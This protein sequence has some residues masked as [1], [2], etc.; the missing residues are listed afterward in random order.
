M[1]FSVLVIALIAAIVLPV[2]LHLRTRGNNKPRPANLPPGS[3][4]LPVIGQSLA[5]LRAMRT[6]TA[7]RWIQGRVARYGPVSKLSLFG[8][9]TVL[10]T[11]PAAN[12]FVFFSD[13][14]LAMKQPRSVAMILGER[15]ISE[16]TGDDHRRIR[17]A[18]AEFLKPD[19]LRKY[20]GKI[21][22]EVRRHLDESWD[23]RRAVTVMPLMKRLTFGIISS[24]LFGLAPGH[25]R[26][27]LAGDFARIAEGM[28]AI[29]VDLPFTAFRRS[30]RSSARARRLL[31]KI[32]RETKAKLERGEASRSS[33]LIACL[34]SLADERGA[35]LLSEEEI[36]DN[37]MVTLVAGNDTSSV[38]LTFMVRQLANDPDTLAAMVQEHEEVA[39]SKVD[40]E[41]L[42]WE[43]LGK[44][45]LT[46]RVALETLRLVPPLF[47]NFRRAT[48]DVEFDGFIIPKGWQVFWVS[49]VT[50][51]DASIFHEPAKFDPFRFKDGSPATAPPCSFVAFGGGPRIC[52]GMEFARVETLVTMHYL[53]RRF[54]WKLCCSQ[55]ENTFVRDPLPSPRNGLPIEIE[56]RASPSR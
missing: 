17:G 24:L 9:P 4:G 55:S 54:K 52:A 44:M 15:S 39:G 20:V 45:K 14:A 32:T 13:D 33:D 25:V 2:I 10:L 28:W 35:P 7:D 56:R 30:L 43:D 37:A 26:D 51:M 41:A 46:W 6:N 8:T 27:A 47:G 22:G 42:T 38:L 18:L 1:A 50:H 23:G 5:L 49:S 16:L 53:V 3:M 29:P 31:E 19:M 36:V 11:G 48:K 40:G 21:D 12:K 34:L